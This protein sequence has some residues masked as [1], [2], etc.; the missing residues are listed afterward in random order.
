MVQ[1]EVNGYQSGP[2]LRPGSGA[3][4]TIYVTFGTN[5]PGDLANGPVNDYFR[6]V[7]RLPGFLLF[8]LGF[9]FWFTFHALFSI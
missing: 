6:L 3:A 7:I 1:R 8:A 5:V 9:S 4:T 2:G